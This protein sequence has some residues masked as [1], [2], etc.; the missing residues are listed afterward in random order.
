MSLVAEN[1][2]YKLRQ[3][4]QEGK[5]TFIRVHQSNLANPCAKSN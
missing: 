1:P 5:I 2:L 4:E 3:R